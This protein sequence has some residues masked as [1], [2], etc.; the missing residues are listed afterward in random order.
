VGFAPEGPQKCHKRVCN[1][2][3][4][5][6][7]R[8]T[9][10]CLKDYVLAASMLAIPSEGRSYWWSA[11]WVPTVP[12]GGGGSQSR[13]TDRGNPLLEIC[14]PQIGCSQASTQLVCSRAAPLPCSWTFAARELVCSLASA[15]LLSKHSIPRGI[16]PTPCYIQ[17]LL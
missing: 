4:A 16:A 15:S 3:L 8:S 17:F 12:I 1:L 6:G 13:A 10:P 11:S 14:C 2:S 9:S 5:S 7:D